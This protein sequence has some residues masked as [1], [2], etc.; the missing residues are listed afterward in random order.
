MVIT[1]LIKYIVGTYNHMASFQSRRSGLLRLQGR[2]GI[3]FLTISLNLLGGTGLVVVDL[4][5]S[6]TALLGP[7][8]VDDGEDEERVRG[9]G[10]TG[11]GVV[12]GDRTS[13]MEWYV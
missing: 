1:H 9:V 8:E 6:L 7:W 3:I 4:S 2:L 11:K 5:A 10:H 12:P 13:A